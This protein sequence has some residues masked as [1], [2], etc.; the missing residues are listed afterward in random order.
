LYYKP[1]SLL[2]LLWLEW[3]P[4]VMAEPRQEWQGVNAL[5][6]KPITSM[7]DLLWFE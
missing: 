6:Y 4:M 5:Y 1:T 2:G 7:L 3:F